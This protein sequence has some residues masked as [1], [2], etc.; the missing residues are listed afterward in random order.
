MP[1]YQYH[2]ELGHTFEEVRHIVERDA[3]I[4]CP[5]GPL[6]RPSLGLREEKSLG[7]LAVCDRPGHRVEIAGAPVFIA[8]PGV[9]NRAR[10]HRDRDGK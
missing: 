8:H 10:Y 6:G 9:G 4:K 1:T 5:V 3:P 2:C 7:I